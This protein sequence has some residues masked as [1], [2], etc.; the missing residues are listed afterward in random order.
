MGFGQHTKTDHGGRATGYP[1]PRADVKVGR[2]TKVE[3]MAGVN[4]ADI[5]D[6]KISAH[7][8]VTIRYNGGSLVCRLIGTN[9]VEINA[10]ATVVIDTGG[11]NT[12]T[13]RRHVMN[14]LN[15]NG[16]GISLW[17]DIKRGGNV[18]VLPSNIA[19]ERTEIVFRNRVMF[20]KVG[21]FVTDMTD[22]IIPPVTGNVS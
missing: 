3:I 11:W 4:D 17:W 5:I 15:R 16:V 14:F 21:G 8:E 22:H 1:V 12:V 10:D 6:A 18:L 19:N 9:I 20:N 7:N 2:F 13:T